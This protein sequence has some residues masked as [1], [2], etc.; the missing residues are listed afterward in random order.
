[1]ILEENSF[2]ESVLFHS[3]GQQVEI[4][5]FQFVTGGCINNAIQ[6]CTAERDFFLKW[7][8]EANEDLFHA[9]VK[10]L[11]LLRSAKALKVPEVIASGKIEN[12]CYLLEEFLPETNP[13]SNFWE[14]FGEKLA[15]LHSNTSP[16]EK[17]GLNHDNF[18]GRLAQK[19]EWRDSWLDFLIECRLEPQIGLAFYNGAEVI[20]SEVWMKEIAMYF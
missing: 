14:D 10:G 9:E 16:N 13:S 15:Q 19:N 17:F 2:F 18:I 3:L 11:K 7:N 12:K 20:D 5:S 4:Q 1:M 8:E 6:L